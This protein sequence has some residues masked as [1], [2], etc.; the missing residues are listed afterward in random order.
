MVVLYPEIFPIEFISEFIASHKGLAGFIWFAVLFAPLIYLLTPGGKKTF[1]KWPFFVFASSISLIIATQLTLIAKWD[2]SYISFLTGVFGLFL[3]WWTQTETKIDPKRILLISLSFFW[4]AGTL[5]FGLFALRTAREEIKKDAMENQ[6]EVIDT[7]VMRINKNFDERSATLTSFAGDEEIKK[8]VKNS[9]Q[10]VAIGIAKEIYEK[11]DNAERV[12]IYDEEGIAVGVYP[13][14][15]LAQ[16]TNFSSRDYFQQTLKT[17]KGYVSPVFENII[18]AASIIH[19]EPIFEENNFIGMMGV[20]LDLNRLALLYQVDGTI[21]YNL[22]AVDDK[23]TIVFDSDFTKIGLSEAQFAFAKPRFL[24]SQF[25]TIKIEQSAYTPRWS[26]SLE[27]P[28]AP[29]VAKLS[30]MHIIL[31]LLLI[32]NCLFSIA[33]AVAAGARRKVQDEPQIVPASV[34]SNPR[35]V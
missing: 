2:I 12:L 30:S 32:V 19:T 35:F 21:E 26:V 13:R 4:I 34:L 22:R 10:E 8:S 27:T 31:S 29:L 17:Y 33:A 6:Q 7:L 18:G 25:E 3:V 1:L 14:N 5:L 28:V 23:G 24:S 16:G 15:T 11:L 9:D 20:A